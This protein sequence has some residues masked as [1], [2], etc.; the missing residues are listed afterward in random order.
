MRESYLVATTSLLILVL[1]GCN[2][3]STKN[4]NNRP[5]YTNANP[6]QS[7]VPE[8]PNLSV[9]IS[10]QQYDIGP[11]SNYNLS[12]PTNFIRISLE[13]CIENALRDSRIVRELGGTVLRSPETIRTEDDPAAAYTDPRFGEEA[14]LAAFDASFNNQLL[15]QNNDR[16]F[17]STFIGDDGRLNQNV[18]NNISTL[19]KQSANGGRYSLTHQIL[20]DQNNTPANRFTNGQSYDTFLGAE[21][22]QP[23][24]QGRSSLFNRIAGPNNLPGVNNGV[25]IARTNTDI[26][27]A[28]FEQGIRDLVSNVE[29]A[30]WDLYFAYRDLEAKIE[31]RNGAYDIW[32]ALKAKE[33]DESS[34][35]VLQAEEQYYLFASRVDDAVFGQLNDGTRTNNGS[36]GGTFRGNAGVRIAE[37]RLRLL[38]GYALNDGLLIV[39]Q[40][41]PVEANVLFDWDQ[42]KVDALTQRIELRRQRWVMKREQLNYLA[43]KNHLLPRLDLIGRY[44]VRGFGNDLF[45]NDG[46][47]PALPSTDPQD[48]SD[49]FATFLNG[50]LQEW[51]LGVDF[52]LP[53][54]FRR[55][56]AAVRNSE[57]RYSREKKILR[58]QE[59][60]II[61][62]LSNSVNELERTQTLLATNARRLDASNR[63]F[64]AI[65]EEHKQDNTTIDLVLESQRRVIDAKLDY[66]RAQVSHMLAIKSIHFE[67]GTLLR[68][69][70]VSLS[71]KGWCSNDFAQAVARENA[72]SQPINHYCPGLK[73]ANP[74]N[75]P[76]LTFGSSEAIREAKKDTATT[77]Q[78]ASKTKK[79][80]KRKPKT[81]ISN[82]IEQDTILTALAKKISKEEEKQTLTATNASMAADQKKNRQQ[83]KINLANVVK[84]NTSRNSD[85]KKQSPPA[86]KKKITTKSFFEQWFSKNDDP[87]TK[88][89]IS[90]NNAGRQKQAVRPIAGKKT[91]RTSNPPTSARP[92]RYQSASAK[93]ANPRSPGSMSQT[94]PAKTQTANKRKPAIDFSKL[95]FQLP[96]LSPKKSTRRTPAKQP[97]TSKKPSGPVETKLT[98]LK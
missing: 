2:S 40:D 56:L 72:K 16:L 90:T 97:T 80:K 8:S 58:E 63:Q 84:N 87:K 54:G 15:F 19:S 47:N 44:R 51:E 5:I 3:L 35:T 64:Q 32:K 36:T 21:V 85:R 7:L 48:D 4:R 62:G 59:R 71:E 41:I 52:N 11:A 83:S 14:A 78:L 61:Y 30:Y 24:L 38:A 81:A 57:L 25:L 6:Y 76:Q 88:R 1:V 10:E 18:F 55:Q 95:K 74:L 86:P 93:T 75:Q 12:S 92:S 39:P 50:D 60:E 9:P 29:N 20:F 67:K 66:F 53:I 26:E 37:R 98:D 89:S 94:T 28:E 69:H 27:L 73:V 13:Q 68:Y 31:A 79:K 70:N 91:G 33:D 82:E 34:A 17:N 46:F 77:K 45:G 22:R 43:N 49:A 23:L 96:G 42:V 65:Q